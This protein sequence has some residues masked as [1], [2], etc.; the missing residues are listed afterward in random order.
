MNHSK[1]RSM[2]WYS[3]ICDDADPNGLCMGWFIVGFTTLR[4]ELVLKANLKDGLPSLQL[5]W[6]LR[7]IDFYRKVVF[8]PAIRQGPHKSGWWHWILHHS[9]KAIL[10]HMFPHSVATWVTLHHIHSVSMMLVRF[11]T[12]ASTGLHISSVS[13]SSIFCF[14]LINSEHVRTNSWSGGFQTWGYRQLSRSHST[15]T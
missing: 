3:L 9:D 1:Y 4:N 13:H 6:T 8:Q 12:I 10:L 2:I 11:C 14:F 7:I 15:M 5:I